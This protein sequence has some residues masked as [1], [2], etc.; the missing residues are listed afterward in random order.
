MKLIWVLNSS[1]FE[2]N[3]V[4]KTSDDKILAVDCKVSLDNNALF[5]HKELVSGLN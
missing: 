1:L 4:L 3:P 2:I 5:E